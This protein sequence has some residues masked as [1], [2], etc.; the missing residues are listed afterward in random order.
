[1]VDKIKPSGSVPEPPL[2]PPPIEE[3]E[4]PL[5]KS[6]RSVLNLFQ[7]HLQGHRPQPWWECRLKPDDYTQVLRT[8]DVDESLRDYVK[9]QDTVSYS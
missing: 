5:S 9:I 7:L 8:L 6:A 1:M 2:T 4:K 3:K